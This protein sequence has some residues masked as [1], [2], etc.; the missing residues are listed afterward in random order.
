M[1]ANRGR[2]TA[3]ELAVRRAAHRLGLRYRVGVRP[4]GNVRRTA[5]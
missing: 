4:I 5:E 1:I 2:D 3:P